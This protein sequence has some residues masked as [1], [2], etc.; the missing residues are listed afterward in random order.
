MMAT[1]VLKQFRNKIETKVQ[2]TG[3]SMDEFVYLGDIEDSLKELGW[4]PYD[5]N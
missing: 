1:D 2:G 3:T 4:S 5:Q